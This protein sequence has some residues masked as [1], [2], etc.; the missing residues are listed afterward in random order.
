MGKWKNL[1]MEEWKN[2]CTKHEQPFIFSAILETFFLG[3]EYSFSQTN[4]SKY[5]SKLFPSLTF[6]GYK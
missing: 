4:I 3:L 5:L 1:R 6:K 2:G